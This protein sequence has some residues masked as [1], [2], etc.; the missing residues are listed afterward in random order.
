MF[1]AVS[2]ARQLGLLV[3]AF[4]VMI[5][6]SVSL[7][8]YA[9]SNV[10]SGA[11]RLVAK[12]NTKMAVLLSVV[13]SLNDV[14]ERMLRLIRSRDPDAIE[15]MIGERAKLSKS[16]KDRVTAAAGPSS[17]MAQSLDRLLQANDRV[18][19]Q[20]LRGENAIAQQLF[21]EESAP[22]LDAVMAETQK[23]EASLKKELEQEAASAAAS[24]HR[25]QLFTFSLVGISTAVL[26]FL[27]I[28]LVRNIRRRLRQAVDSLS[29][30]AD[31]M[32]ASAGQVASASQ[33]LAQGASEQAAS[34]ENT[35]ESAG[36]VRS[37][38][39][40]SAQ[41]AHSAADLMGETT[42]VVDDAN[43]RLEAMLESMREI[44]STSEKISN[45]IRVIDDIAF[46]TNVLALNAAVEAARAGD[47]GLGFA[48]VADEVRGLAQR[49]AQAAKDTAALIEQAIQSS[50]EG[51]K[52][53]TH[54]AEAIH[55]IRTSAA[56]VKQ[57][58]DGVSSGSQEQASGVDTIA[59][60]VAEMDKVTQ[61]TAA[62]AEETS[63]AA[64]QLSA[65]S[66]TLRT[67]V[68]ELGVM[69]G[70]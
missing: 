33:S 13:D 3:A 64:Q 18:T 68:S 34:L 59:R 66:E 15:Q 63:A 26:L 70:A 25:T 28:M 29:S 43:S 42:R 16:A 20:L 48:V 36:R 54:V 57:L 52:R 7:L 19:E 44:N 9:I 11:S 23:I 37:V 5:V 6:V 8:S 1:R 61:G 27:A 17:P 49:S 46:Q 30:S 50:H 40:S 53:L 12:A 47:S 65:E 35:S 67:V 56:Q 60:L 62:N 4:V 38:S 32:A 39:Q 2:I 10:T 22:C 51:N 24:S 55:S 14:Q 31:Q 41:H 45:I 69:L 58:V 21:M